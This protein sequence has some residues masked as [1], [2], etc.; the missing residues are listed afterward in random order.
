MAENKTLRNKPLA[1]AIFELRWELQDADSGAKIDPNYKILIGSI[2]DNLKTD[3]PFYEQLPTA[4]IL[5]EIAGYIVQHRFR[6]GK[7]KWPLVQIGPGIITLNDTE[8][9]VWEDFEKR[10]ENLVD[11]LFKVYP[12]AESNLKINSLLLR[13]IDA[14]DFDY[15]KENTFD[16][17]KKLKITI[18]ID[19]M[20]FEG[21]D[22]NYP[23]DN[24]DLKFS[25]PI[26]NFDGILML[27]FL[28]GKRKQV[29]AFIWETNIR[30]IGK[31][32]YAS[33]TQ[34]LNWTNNAHELT[35]D[36]FFK[37]IDGELLRRF[38]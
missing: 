15:A 32:I 3:Y 11:V 26:D 29:D 6:T 33:K 31:D 34:I 17:F 14:V 36:W 20:L 4:A 7:N 18:E 21:S 38:E 5:D 13:Y 35:H 25:F 30:S 10:I 16:F 28:R 22:V 8:G 23:P 2:Y 24:F 9:Y 1:E 37:M 19:K 27:R 12:D